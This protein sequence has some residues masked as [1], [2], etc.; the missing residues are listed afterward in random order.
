MT[1]R[2]IDDSAQNAKRALEH[3]DREWIILRRVAVIIERGWRDLLA[4]DELTRSYTSGLTP[5]HAQPGLQVDLA[6][7]KS[8][9][10]PPKRG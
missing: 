8:G 6:Q 4:I 9:A 5:G 2:V 3:G 10:S 7:R 1:I